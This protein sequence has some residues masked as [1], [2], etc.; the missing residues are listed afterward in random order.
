MYS[1]YKTI[2]YLNI[3][4]IIGIDFKTKILWDPYLETPGYN[5]VR[6]AVFGFPDCRSYSFLK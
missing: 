4:H 6:K 2:T 5:C 3:A 1:R